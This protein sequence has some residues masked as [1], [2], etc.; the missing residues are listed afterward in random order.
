M[1]VRTKIII[2][3]IVIIIIAALVYGLSPFIDSY[4]ANGHI[5]IS[6]IKLLMTPSEV[7]KL[8]GK[9]NPIGGFGADFI[10][11]QNET[12]TMAYSFDGL[13]KGKVGYI[14]ISNPDYN[15]F[16]V[17]PGDAPEKSK[18]ILEKHG[19]KEDETNKSFFKRGSI[20]IYIMS[21]RIRINIEDWTLRG[22]VY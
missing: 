1:K 6:G 17:H 9:G 12:I 18:P 3:A 15:I 22:R 10:K 11:Y 20:G 4:R 14:E 2:M 16:D 19:F 8:V 21:D 5:N 7:E 13:L